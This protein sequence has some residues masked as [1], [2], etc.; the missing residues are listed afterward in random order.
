KLLEDPTDTHFDFEPLIHGSMKEKIPDLELAIDGFITP[1]QAGKLSVIKKHYENLQARKADLEE[2]IL[3]LAVPYT[4]EIN[5]ILTVPSF[6]DIFSAIAVVSE[7]GADMDVFPTAKHLCSW[8]G[9]TPTN[10]E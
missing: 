1:E 10:N 6:K 3:S 8:A 2:L 7:I 9:L 5:L 4:E